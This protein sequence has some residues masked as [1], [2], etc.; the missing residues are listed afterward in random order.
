VVHEGDDN[1]FVVF[2]VVFDELIELC[3]LLL[4]LF[5]LLLLL[6]HA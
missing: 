5:R 2:E 4:A 3:L 6:T 1:F